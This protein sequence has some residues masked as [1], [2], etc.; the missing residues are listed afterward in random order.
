MKVNVPPRAILFLPKTSLLTAT[1]HWTTV[2]GGLHKPDVCHQCCLFTQQTHFGIDHRRVPSSRR[3]TQI[4]VELVE[5]KTF[6]TL[7]SSFWF[8]GR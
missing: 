6:H 4:E 2:R 1:R 3:C 5:A 8:E 7:T